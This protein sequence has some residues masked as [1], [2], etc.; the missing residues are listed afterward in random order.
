MK[1]KK[2]IKTVITVLAVFIAV[3]II[4]N[5]DKALATQ[6]GED[7]VYAELTDVQ[8]DDSHSINIYAHTH[9][10]YAYDEG[11]YGWIVDGYVVGNDGVGSDNVNVEVLQ[12][13]EQYGYGTSQLCF[14]YY[15]YGHSFINDYRG[16]IYIY[17][18]IYEWG[19]LD[20]CIEY[21]P[22]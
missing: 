18:S 12:L 7:D 6:T 17:V 5:P 20:S 10:S 22:I 9:V 4:K 21:K 8:L 15:F 1:V 19:N 13:D 14:K 3:I 11:A 16:Y 2:I